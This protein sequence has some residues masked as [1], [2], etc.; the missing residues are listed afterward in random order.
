[1]ERQ[2]LPAL[3]GKIT[4]YSCC[5]EYLAV[6]INGR[7]HEDPREQLDEKRLGDLHKIELGETS[8]SRGRR[9]LYFS[10]SSGLQWYLSAA[11]GIETPFHREGR[12]WEGEGYCRALPLSPA[13]ISRP[14]K[15]KKEKYLFF[16]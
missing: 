13:T 11:R 1:L 10:V 16:F 6:T 9:P 8:R 4:Y 3:L 15:K 14:G 2:K 7:K 5:T 12:V